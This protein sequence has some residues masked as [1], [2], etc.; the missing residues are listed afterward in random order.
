MALGRVYRRMREAKPAM[1]QTAEH[2]ELSIVCEN[3]AFTYRGVS[4]P[5]WRIVS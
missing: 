1:A 4:L 3:N 5:N 2:L